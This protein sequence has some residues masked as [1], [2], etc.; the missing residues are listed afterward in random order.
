[1]RK[2]A[3]IFLSLFFLMVSFGHAVEQG[4]IA[5]AAEG[6]NASSKVSSVAARSPYFLI[7]DRSGK[8][9]EAVN[10][11][12][13]EAKG[14]AGTSVVP[15]L[16]Q[17]GVTVVVAGEFGIRM[18]EAMKGKGMRYLEFKGRAEEAVKRVLE[19]KE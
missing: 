7:F 3:L 11:P 6:K 1:M 19:A 10:N 15:F 12:Y 5:I 4:Q 8:L 14:G 16:F 18:I 2:I 9:L 13:K 17:K